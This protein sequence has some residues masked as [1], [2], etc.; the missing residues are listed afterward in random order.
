MPGTL[1][2]GTVEKYQLLRGARVDRKSVA[3]DK[4][5]TASKLVSGS[6]GM[7]DNTTGLW[8]VPASVT[9]EGLDDT[10]VV[11]QFAVINR[12]TDKTDVTGSDALEIINP[13]QGF[14][15]FVSSLHSALVT[16]FASFAVGKKVFY[17]ITESAYKQAVGAVTS[18]L[19]GRVIEYS[20]KGMVIAVEPVIK[21]VTAS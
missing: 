16:N 12:G 8:K 18:I 11:H 3:Y 20:P 6:I 7:L 2:T 9:V 4:T 15:I 19:V 17:D 10:V 1:Y 21:S 5:A 13:G 14:E